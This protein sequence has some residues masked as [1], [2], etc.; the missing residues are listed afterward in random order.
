L[1]G[2][3]HVL[4]FVAV[5]NK[6]LMRSYKI[7]LKKSGEKTPYVEL[8]EIG[9]SMDFVLRRT[10]LAS[11]DL[12]KSACKQPKE[13]KVKKVKNVSKDVFGSTMGRVHMPKQNLNK[14]PT[15]NM[16]GL[17]RTVAE[18]KVE[19]AKRVAT[20]K[21]KDNPNLIPLGAEGNNSNSSPGPSNSAL[22]KL[23]TS[24]PKMLL[25]LSS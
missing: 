9:P 25:N 3:E 23:N 17:K 16:K 14:L 4:Q 22:A 11:A 7:I 15:R 8:E 20:R 19:R 6:V 12:F 24:R 13:L 1:E 5:E 18:K 2:I 21:Q 10:K